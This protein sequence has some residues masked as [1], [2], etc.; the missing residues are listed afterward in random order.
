[1]WATRREERPE[2]CPHIHSRTLDKGDI[3]HYPDFIPYLGEADLCGLDLRK[4]NFRGADLHGVD[5]SGAD[6]RGAD[7]WYADLTGAILDGARF[8]NMTLWPYGFN[9]KEAGAFW[10]PK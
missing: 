4:A 6:L 1:M 7:V 2:S 9:P 8:S 5:L 10:E 3:W